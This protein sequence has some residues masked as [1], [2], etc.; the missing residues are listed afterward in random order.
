MERQRSREH[1]YFFQKK[2]VFNRSHSTLE[3]LK[4]TAAKNI[5]F[6][7]ETKLRKYETDERLEEVLYEEKQIMSKRQSSEYILLYIDLLEILEK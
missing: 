5:I 7:E 1:D 3:G 6:M 2:A 4:E